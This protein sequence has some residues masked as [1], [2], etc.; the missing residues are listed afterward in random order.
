M[1]LIVFICF[2]VL[3]PSASQSQTA[4][5]VIAANSD[6]RHLFMKEHLELLPPSTHENFLWSW[7]YHKGLGVP[8][9]FRKALEFGLAT[10]EDGRPTVPFVSD[11]IIENFLLQQDIYKL[12]QLTAHLETACR[13]NWDCAF[14]SVWK[15]IDI[16]GDDNISLAE[17]AKFQ[18]RL[19]KLAYV[20]NSNLY[21]LFDSRHASGMVIGSV[22]ILPIA[23]SSILNSFDYNND[24]LLQKDEVIGDNEFAAMVG[25]DTEAIFARYKFGEFRKHLF[26]RFWDLTEV[27]LRGD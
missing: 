8:R 17:I 5:D 16:T 19:A 1:K 7:K 2:L 21:Y 26:A 27:I 15:F 6:W 4:E 23:A 20:E 10:V 13:D 12:Q 24:G 3:L 25:I 18:R 22:L 9:D 11:L 14:Q